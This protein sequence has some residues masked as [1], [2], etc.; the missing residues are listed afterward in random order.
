MGAALSFVSSDNPDACLQIMEDSLTEIKNKIRA[1][2][3]R[4]SDQQDLPL[5]KREI[6]ATIRAWDVYIDGIEKMF[7]EEVG[8][9]YGEKL[10]GY[11]AETLV[12]ARDSLFGFEDGRGSERAVQ[13]VEGKSKSEEH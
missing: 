7:K 2:K 9:N 5:L 11:I 1:A 13:G 4:W 10:D 12:E 8:D 3:L 6:G